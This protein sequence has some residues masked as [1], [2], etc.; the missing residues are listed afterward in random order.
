[1]LLRIAHQQQ[2]SVALLGD[3]GETFELTGGKQPGLVNE[4]HSILRSL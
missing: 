1:V 4:H 3:C 2:A